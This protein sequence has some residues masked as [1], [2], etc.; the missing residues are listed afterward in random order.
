M[1]N[2]GEK[3]S[4]PV[5]HPCSVALVAAELGPTRFPILTSELSTT[6]YAH[7][8]DWRHSQLLRWI[9]SR[10]SPARSFDTVMGPLR[11]QHQIL[12]SVIAPVAVNVMHGLLVGKGPPDRL[13]HYESVLK[14]V[15]TTIRHWVIGS[16][17]HDITRP[18]DKP[19]PVPPGMRGRIGPSH[20]LMFAGDG[21]KTRPRRRGISERLLRPA[22][23]TK[24]S[25]C[26]FV[27][28]PGMIPHNKKDCNIVSAAENAKR[29]WDMGGK[30][31]ELF[32]EV[33]AT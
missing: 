8:F 26:H 31:V 3:L 32:G 16:I 4:R 25:R 10:L 12:Q 1:S 21:T 27:A 5:S 14:E 20:S 33:K 28:S 29:K 24:D 11:E 19:S 13:A 7:E 15:P 18:S 22:N 17:D 23:L 6:T 9:P 2:G 30:L